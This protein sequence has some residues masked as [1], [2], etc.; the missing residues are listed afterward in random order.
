MMAGNADTSDVLL[1]IEGDV[2][3]LNKDVTLQTKFGD[4]HWYLKATH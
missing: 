1:K 2:A 3:C 4:I